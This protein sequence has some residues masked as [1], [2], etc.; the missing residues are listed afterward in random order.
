MPRHWIESKSTQF[1][2]R[3]NRKRSAKCSD[4]SFLTPVQVFRLHQCLAAAPPPHPPSAPSQSPSFPCLL[5]CTH[6][7]CIWSE[8]TND[9]KP[10]NSEC[11]SVN[12]SS[13]LGG[14]TGWALPTFSPCREGTE[15][16]RLWKLS[17]MWSLRLRSSALWCARLSACN[18]K[19]H[20]AFRA[21]WAE[22]SGCPTNTTHFCSC[23]VPLRLYNQ[24]PAVVS[25]ASIQF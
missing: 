12:V 18:E 13:V 23:Q 17:L 20:T 1:H 21:A 10:N 22:D 24:D 3:Q 8:T 2:W 16:R 5:W 4:Y 19:S 11:E 7:A 6:E 14:L 25:C 9:I 15:S